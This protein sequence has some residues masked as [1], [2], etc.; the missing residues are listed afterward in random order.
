MRGAQDAGPQ[1]TAAP[2]RRGL[3]RPWAV[4]AAALGVLW[5][6][7]AAAYWP[8]LDS[9][10]LTD[11]V[12]YLIECFGNDGSAWAM[13]SHTC[14][15]NHTTRIE[16]GDT[17][18]FR[19][20]FYLALVLNI[21]TFRTNLSA[22]QATGIV[23][24]GLAVLCVMRL[25]RRFCAPPRGGGAGGRLS[26]GD[27]RLWLPPAMTAFWA[28]SFMNILSVS[29][30]NIISYMVFV[31]LVASALNLLHL[32]T[33]E[34][35]VGRT[36]RGALVAGA[37]V[38]LAAAAMMYEVGQVIAV[39]VGLVLAGLEAGRRRWGRG[40]ALLALFVLIAAGYQVVNA[41]DRHIHQGQFPVDSEA[42]TMLPRAF[43]LD[44]IR[45]IGRAGLYTVVQPYFPSPDHL[46]MFTRVFIN[47]L[48][49]EKWRWDGW[50]ILSLVV[51]ATWLALLLRALPRMLKRENRAAAA[52]WLFLMVFLL[53]FEAILAVGRLNVRFREE[54]LSANSYYAYTP[55]LFWTLAAVR[56]WSLDPG[57]ASPR[58]RAA[59]RAA[60]A[61]LLAGT[62][63]LSG[64]GL[65]VVHGGTRDF[66]N[67]V[68]P[69]RS[70]LDPVA[71]FLRRQPN[72]SRVRLAFETTFRGPMPCLRGVPV[73]S[74][75]FHPFEDN[76]S[77]DYVVQFE[78]DFVN[79]VAADLYRHTHPGAPAPLF[80]DL[81]KIGTKQHVYYYRGMYHGVAY[82]YNVMAVAPPAATLD[83][84]YEAARRLWGS[85]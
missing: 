52:W 59:W 45:N 70:R 83:A 80:P 61:V 28:A 32:Y 73:T 23:L 17:T 63:V 16:P 8:S 39:L 74:V 7:L 77:P 15:Y 57:P 60:W 11:Q 84:A 36:A 35:P 49:W 68:A 20:L 79:I 64:R 72:P 21:T 26:A 34:P 66:S 44:T 14:S 4:D 75:F 76:Y 43:S 85:G 31:M 48:S 13:F 37:W 58:R 22:Q 46:V 82:G 51:L 40:A 62:L 54:I 24:H 41:W 9:L 10:S 78:P 19:P 3:L 81:V 50:T 6:A 33:A 27:L 55:L 47:E 67:F 42:A 2:G 65:W 56:A 5:L 12:D 53:G 1:A 38:L 69:L 71:A 30:I 18:I 25:M 29:Y